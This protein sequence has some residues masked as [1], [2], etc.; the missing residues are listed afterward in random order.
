[1]TLVDAFAN[2]V[3]AGADAVIY[4]SCDVNSA[5]A[6][7]WS[8][9]I[10]LDGIAAN[11]QPVVGQVISFGTSNGS[12]RHTYTIIEVDADTTTSVY[13]WLDR[14]L[15]ASLAN[16]DLAFPGPAGSLNLAFHRD[17]MAF[18]SRPLALPNPG[19]NVMS[20]V[21]SYNDVAMR[22]TMQYNITQMGTIVTLDLLCGVKVLDTNLG[23]LLLG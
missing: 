17:A 22:V 11:L 10:L 18:V 21:G 13:I 1:V 5:Y 6:A 2:T 23:C 4:K 12:D 16:N 14:P 7:N 8:K 9:A 3:A 19:L 15:S 20:A